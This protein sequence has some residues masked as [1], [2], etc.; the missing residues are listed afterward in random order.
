MA[1]KKSHKKSK[2]NE[3]Q[4]QNQ[5]QNENTQPNF[6]NIDM[7]Q[8]SSMLNNIDMS[9][10]SSILGNNMFGSGDSQENAANILQ[11]DKSAA[12]INAIKPLM[13]SERAQILDMILQLY[14]ISK[15]I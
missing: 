1:S 3:N 12:I 11:G 10:L 9:K 14:N 13:S 8:L 15:L 7:S 2:S 5:N 4:N 6:N